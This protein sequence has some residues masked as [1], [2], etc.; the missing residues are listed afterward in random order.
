ML[1][2]IVN[3]E[4][5]ENIHQVLCNGLKC[6][7]IPNNPCQDRRKDYD[8]PRKWSLRSFNQSAL[9]LFLT[10][11]I[12][13]HWG[14]SDRCSRVIYTRPHLPPPKLTQTQPQL[15][16]LHYYCSYFYDDDIRPVWHALSQIPPKKASLELIRSFLGGGSYWPFHKFNSSFTIYL[17]F[18]PMTMICLVSRWFV[19]SVNALQWILNGFSVLLLFAAGPPLPHTSFF[20]HFDNSDN[21]GKINHGKVRNIWGG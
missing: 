6:Q 17:A 10:R 21:L 20:Y 4:A 8:A 3:C 7:V 9:W 12:W 5:Q 15:Q 1:L 11:A 18:H 19:W 16:I 14:W 13:G 2:L